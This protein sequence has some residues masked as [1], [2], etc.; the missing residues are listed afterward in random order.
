MIGL[1]AISGIPVDADNP[2]L[3]VL[4]ALVA[5]ALDEGVFRGAVVHIRQGGR[6]IWH[7]AYG[8][9][10]VT[11]RRRPM[12]ADLLFD[13]ASL[14]KPIATATAV[15]QLWEEGA[16]DIDRPVADYLP[17]FGAAGKGRV[18]LRHLLTHTAGLPAWIRLYLHTSSTGEAIAY[19]CRLTPAAPP[20]EVL[21]YSDLGFI[22]LGELVARCSGKALD[23]HVAARLAPYL[24]W[25]RTRFRPPPEWH[26]QCV[27]TEEGNAYERAAAGEEGAGYPWRTDVLVGEVHD[28]NCHYLFGGVAG[29]AGL[30]GTAEEVGRFGQAMLDGGRT[31]R[32][33]L[34][35]EATV[36]EATRDQ[37]DA[38]LGQGVGLGWRGRRGSGSMGTRASERAFGHTGFTGTAL[39]IDPPRDL[40]V[41]LLTNRVHPRVDTRIDEFRPIFHDAV[42]EALD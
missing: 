33:R 24:G 14:T 2:R 23:A 21:E 13:L 8:W 27:A 12:Q 6:V 15:L 20:G 35:N 9:A 1:A 30:F 28:G 41:V 7:R 29:H 31:E 42:L 10:E 37:I 34:L 11:P 25:E 17:A 19:I 39:L 4:D 5:R 36:V 40:V 32:G 26:D 22:L 38:R 3:A 18:T 16:L